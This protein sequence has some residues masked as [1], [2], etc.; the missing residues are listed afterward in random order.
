MSV[1]AEAPIRADPAIVGAHIAGTFSDAS[2]HSAQSHLVYAARAGVWWLFTLT[3]AADSI[4]GSN[5]V[6]KAYRSSTSDLA[7]A[8]WL[9]AADSP[10]AA[11]S[12]STNC[13]SCSMG[14]GRALGVVSL[15]EGGV[16]VVHAEMAMAADGQNGLTAHIRA[17]VTATA[18][19]WE[20]W[21]YH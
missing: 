17:T 8:T 9:A 13:V 5:H 10:G 15:N 2:G 16:D 18:I 6:V 4:G 1:A 14:G 11:V 3:S 21:N 19:T 20:A 12:A 7:T